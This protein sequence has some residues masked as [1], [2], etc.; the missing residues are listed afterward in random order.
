MKT[1][2]RVV[3]FWLVLLV[4]PLAKAAE[5]VILVLGDS[6]SAAFGMP[7]EQGW[8]SLLQQRLRAS[9]LPHRVVNASISG[10]TT[11]GGLARL[12]D[13]LARHRPDIVILELGGN[14]G[15]RGLPLAEMEKNLAAMIGLSR[16]A[17]AR[18]VLVEMRIPPNYG[19]VYSEK[20]RAVY[21]DLA[22]RHDL[23][24]VPFFLDG[25]AT[26]AALMQEDG[27]H[28][29]ADA[30]ARLL[31]NVWPTLEPLLEEAAT[32][33]PADGPHHSG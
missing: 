4:A 29:R 10:D 23:P 9:G 1:L 30:Q 18:V 33:E 26:D 3:L 14:D 6:L 16:A 12:P 25:V 21:A 19:P 32:T 11:R 7:L 28:P 2:P 8:V 20:F 24:L 27:I 31:D 15:L 17:G 5:P 13:A 22:R